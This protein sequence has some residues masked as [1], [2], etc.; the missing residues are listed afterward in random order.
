LQVPTPYPFLLDRG[1]LVTEWVEGPTVSHLMDSMATRPGLIA[2]ALE[3]AGNWLRAFHDQQT[4][5]HTFVNADKLVNDARSAISGFDGWRAPPAI[6]KDHLRLLEQI[7]PIV[8]SLPVRVSLLHGDFKPAN[9]I[10]SLDD[11]VAVDVSAIFTGVVVD[12]LVHFL[13]HLDLGLLEPRGC[14]LLPWAGALDAAF[15]RGYDPDGVMV[16]PVVLAWCRLQRALRHYQVPM[17]NENNWTRGMLRKACYA[18]CAGR[19]ANQLH[20]VWEASRPRS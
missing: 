2:R 6:F 13:L 15:L 16:P 8:E 7:K 19:S 12:D 5:T 3:Q 20:R 1:F 18:L 17:E 4:R 11:A 9:M 10:I 14:R